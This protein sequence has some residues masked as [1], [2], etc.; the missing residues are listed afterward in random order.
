MNP[1][2]PGRSRTGTPILAMEADAVLFDMDGTLV[3]SIAVDEAIWADFAHRYG[4]DADEVLGYTH[5]RQTLDSVRHFLPDGR[6]ARSVAADLQARA[7]TCTDGI[8]EVP[9]AASFLEQLTGMPVAVVTSSP[10]DMAR[11][12]LRAAGLPVSGPLVAAEDVVEGKPSPEGYRRAATLLGVDP[13]HCLAFEDAEAGIRA[14][15]ASTAHT[16]VVGS[17][18]SSATAGLPRIPDYTAMTVSPATSGRGARRFRH[19]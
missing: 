9:G 17:H 3:D 15:V 19:P 13:H 11:R 10:R 5:G 6:D 8:V 18:A 2:P 12:R 7:L 4:L 16:V 14:A 1:T